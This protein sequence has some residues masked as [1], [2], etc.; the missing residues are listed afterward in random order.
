[1]V[2]K[3][4]KLRW[5]ITSHC[6]LNCLHCFVGD[7]LKSIQQL[8][9][10]QALLIVDK[11]AEVGIKSISFTTKEPLL[12]NNISNVITYC[13][14]KGISTN[15]ITNG[16][17]LTD[18]LIEKL[19][20]SGLN[21][22]SISLEGVSEKTNDAIRGNGVLN[23]VHNSINVLQN[24]QANT[25]NKILVGIQLTLN[26]LNIKEASLIPTY[27][28]NM[29]IDYLYI[30]DISIDGNAKNNSWLKINRAIYEKTW[31]DILKIYLS[32]ET[33]NYYLISKSLLPWETVFYNLFFSTD[34]PVLPPNC[35]L[36]NNEFSLF[37]DG[38]MSPCISLFANEKVLNAPKIPFLNIDE[39]SYSKYI[40]YISY[41]KNLI[42]Q[43]KLVINCSDC[44]YEH[45]CYPCPASLTD[46][47]FVFDLKTR[48][49]SKK[50]LIQNYI[51]YFFSN[52]EDYNVYFNSGTILMMH[53]NIIKLKRI[54][55]N[56]TISE[57]TYYVSESQWEFV[58][59]IYEETNL[60]SFIPDNSELLKLLIYNNFVCIKK[61]S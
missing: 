14:R 59:N 39:K 19:I 18:Y 9:E 37:P 60:Y 45:K 31:E 49:M 44:Y 17:L 8:D 27:F 34:F 24:K 7:R 43:K 36:L 3:I 32:L 38:S 52:I 6:N 30:G 12:F 26:S 2:I 5:E 47:K 41:V 46:N 4:S 1:M 13:T 57:L 28:N 48:C 53:N 33:K 51:E 16:T 23:K 15:L 61:R 21:S 54:Y 40:S 50:L 11:A 35:G 29:Q 20:E 10:E 56:G 55:P 42:N 25:Y 22:I 58:K